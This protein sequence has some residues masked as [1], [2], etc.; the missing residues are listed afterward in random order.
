MRIPTPV[1]VALAIVAV[2]ACEGIATDPF[3]DVTGSYQEP[4][5]TPLPDGGV[6]LACAS[7]QQILICHS[8]SSLCVDKRVPHEGDS[9]G[10]CAPTSSGAG[11]G[12]GTLGTGGGGGSTT[13]ADSG[14]SCFPA[15]AGCKF[16][17]QCCAGLQCNPPG[18]CFAP[19]GP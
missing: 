10:A 19:I 7:Q 14:T 11:G 12:D 1:A 6:A 4:I 18:I 13:P 3:S 8:A 5:K 9:V 2:A 16:S 17:S 15:G